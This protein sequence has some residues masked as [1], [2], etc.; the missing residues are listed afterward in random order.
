MYQTRDALVFQDS[1]GNFKERKEITDRSISCELVTVS[2]DNNFIL[3]SYTTIKN[4]AG[5]FIN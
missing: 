1:K 4:E 3:S 2:S 5:I